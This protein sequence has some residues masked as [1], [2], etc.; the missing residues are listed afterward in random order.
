MCTKIN[1]KRCKVC[2]KEVIQLS[3]TAQKQYYL[4][5]VM[6]QD[7]K[8]F[9][10]NRLCAEFGLYPSQA[11]TVIEHL[12]T[13]YGKCINCEYDTLK[14]ENVECPKCGK[15]NYNLSDPFLNIKLNTHKEWCFSFCSHLEWSLNFEELDNKEV[16]HYWC[17]G[18]ESFETEEIVSKGELT[19]KA[20]IGNDGKGIYKMK[21]IFGTKSVTNFKNGKSL[22]DCIPKKGAS[23][24]IFIKPKSNEITLE[25]K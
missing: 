7:F 19:T 23:K 9:A 18:I 25:L 22:I 20:W 1:A 21:I 10:T 6:K 12:N 17:S 3:L 11:E 15:L 5:G 13:P 14:E 24:W 8:L 2:N 4:F 16:K